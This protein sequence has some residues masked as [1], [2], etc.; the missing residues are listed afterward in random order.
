M[1]RPHWV[2]PT[3]GGRVCFPRLHCSGSRLLYRERVLRK[4]EDLVAPEFCAFPT[5]AAQ[6]ARSLTGA[7]SPGAGRLLPSAGPVSVS[8]PAGRRVRLVSGL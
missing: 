7:L 6:A 5:P 4:S 2:C 8:S 3:H 1:F